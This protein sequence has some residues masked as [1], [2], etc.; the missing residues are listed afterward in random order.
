M[1]KVMG[2]RY[3]Q[4]GQVGVITLLVMGVLLTMGL[5]VASNI[6]RDL[7]ISRQ[8][9]ETTR[10]FTGAEAGVE[11]ALSNLE[12]EGDQT[13]GSVTTIDEVTVDYTINRLYN[14]ET[15]IF[16]GV[17][18]GVDVTGAADG[19]ILQIVWSKEDDCGSTDIASLLVGVYYNDAGTQRVRYY[20]ASGC[21]RGDGFGT[22]SAV[23][24][25]GYRRR[26][27]LTL[28]S[29]DTLVRIKPLYSDAH[30]RVRP[31][32]WSLPE[33]GVSIRSQASSVPGQEVRS[34]TVNRSLPTAPSVM[35]Y[36]LVSG[37]TIL[38]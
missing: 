21:D 11:E 18:V 12:F 16:E 29:E 22:P 34:I 25:D 7:E 32:S 5:S 10:V 17:T 24:I 31:N 15:R 13:T 23:N 9:S 19:N 8:E 28:T 4:S 33:Q 2:T 37:T 35:D 14:L 36:A 6:N 1:M 27:S 38:K 26:L 30:I 20:T 3:D